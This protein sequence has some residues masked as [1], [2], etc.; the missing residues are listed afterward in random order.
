MFRELL[1][2][3]IHR[4]RPK[5]VFVDADNRITGTG[6]DPAEPVAGTVRGDLVRLTG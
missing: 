6:D 4:L 1:E 3:R 5:A 2:A